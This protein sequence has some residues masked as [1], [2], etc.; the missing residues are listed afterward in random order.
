MPP[1]KNAMEQILLATLAIA[2]WCWAACSYRALRRCRHRLRI[3]EAQQGEAERIG[4][5]RSRFISYLAHETRTL[6]LAVQGGVQLLRKGTGRLPVA[7]LLGLIDAMAI[8]LNALLSV[9]LD[10]QQMDRGMLT[11]RLEPVALPELVRQVVDEFRPLAEA[12]MLYLNPP[13]PATTPSAGLDAVSDAI[14]LRQVLRNLISNALKFTRIGGVTVSLRANLRKD[15]LAIQVMDTGVGLS[16]QQC[17]H[18]FAE[19]AQPHGSEEFSGS[20]LGLSIS[21]SV[22]RALGG[23]LDVESSPGVGSTFTVWVPRTSKA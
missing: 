10:R 14:R 4:L 5:S 22:I 19:H 18:L 16:A 20:G 3:V 12:R 6:A 8:E 17:Q 11:P 1:G 13:G 9:V 21:R 23:E 2:G 15:L 7:D